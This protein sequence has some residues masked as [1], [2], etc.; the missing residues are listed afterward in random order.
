M[1]SS[2]A[3]TRS[4]RGYL[5]RRATEAA[6][7]LITGGFKAAEL[8]Y[9][10][11]PPAEDPTQAPCWNCGGAPDVPVFSCRHY[12]KAAA[13][14]NIVPAI[15]TGAGALAGFM[16]EAAIMH[17]HGRERQPRSVAMDLR[18]GASLPTRPMPDPGCAARHRRGPG[19]EAV[20]LHPASTT[21]ADL[22]DHLGVKEAVVTLDAPW[23]TSAAC[24]SC[25]RTVEVHAPLWR[26]EA[27]PHCAGCGGPWTQAAGG[28]QRIPPVTQQELRPGDAACE[29]AMSRLGLAPGDHVS[30]F[31]DGVD[32]VVALD[33]SPLELFTAVS[34]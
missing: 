30:L 29:I 17:L 24:R 15:Q 28:G 34:T 27:R 25:E 20:P 10:V 31:A 4:P 21:V 26:W 16:A 13:D 6:V 22:L 11:Y 8:W 7:T 18:T 3:S 12:A 14:A 23:V 2:A 19:T 5:A 33:G 32:R 1:C 9:G